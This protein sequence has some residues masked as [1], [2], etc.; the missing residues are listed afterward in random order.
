MLDKSI[1]EKSIVMKLSRETADA[2]KC[3][4]LPEGFS[5]RPFKEG[6]QYHWAKIIASVGE[7]PDNGYALAYFML[8]YYR[9]RIKDVKERCFFIVKDDIPIATAIAWSLFGQPSVHWL[10]VEKEYQGLGLGKAILSAVLECF[11]SLSPKED[12]YV[13]TRTWSHKAVCLYHS[14]GFKMLREET[15]WGNGGAVHKNEYYEA[16]EILKKN[17]P[18][19]IYGSLLSTSI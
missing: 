16:M 6:D 18:P 7:F 17:I 14:L 8:Y 15:V 11:S 2:V 3:P 5:L 10:A 19:N 12:I 1:P 4:V 13:H 9:P